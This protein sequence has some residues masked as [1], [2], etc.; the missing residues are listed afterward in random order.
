VTGLGFAVLG[1]GAISGLIARELGRDPRARRR[2]VVSRDLGRAASFAHEFAFER[3]YDDVDRALADPEVDVV[4]VGTP[5]A[6][7]TALGIRALAAGKHVL[8]EK[9]LGVDAEDARRLVEAARSSGRFAMEGMWM[10]FAPAYRSLIADVR[11]GLI[12]DVRAVRASFGL[13]LGPVGSP[14]WTRERRSSTILDQLIY[15]VTLALDVLGPPEQIMA[16]GE[17]RDDGVDESVWATL[18]FPGQR[19]AQISASMTTFLDPTA[20]VSGRDGWL[21]LPSPFWGADSYRRHVGAVPVPFRSPEDV[22]FARE[23]YGYVPMLSAV[24]DAVSSGAVEHPLHTL[25][26]S[27]AVHRVLD[28]IRRLAAASPPP[29]DARGSEPTS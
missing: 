4:Y 25:D 14:Q 7:H 3:A 16:S 17:I 20:S 15:P 26:D 2:A 6:T 11:S 13:P 9:P 12:G 5:H 8:I 19:H 18:Q 23:G 27:V 24:I 28:R 22:V 21:A 1:T 10:R 29:R